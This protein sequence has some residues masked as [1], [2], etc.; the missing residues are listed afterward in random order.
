M[1]K[2]KQATNNTEATKVGV[3]RRDLFKGAGILGAGALLT[4]T[5]AKT[6][7]AATP[8]KSLDVSDRWYIKKVSKATT[9]YDLSKTQRFNEREGSVRGPGYQNYV[10]EEK[11][12]ERAEAA[13]EIR[14]RGLKENIPGWSL[15]DQALAHAAGYSSRFN[16]VMLQSSPISAR[17]PEEIGAPPYNET[18]EVAAKHLKRAA[19]ALGCAD[20]GITALRREWTYSVGGDGRKIEFADVDQVIEE[21]DR[22]IIPNKMNNIIVVLIPQPLDAI[23]CGQTLLGGGYTGNLAYRLG[24]WTEGAIAEFIRSLGYNAMPEQN[25]TFIT[26]PHAIEA[27]L[28][29]LGRH[30]R[31]IHPDYSM[32]NRLFP[33]L[34]DMP[35]AHDQPIDFGV[36]EFCKTCMKCAEECPAGCISFDRDPTWEIKGPWNNPGHKAWFE[37]AVKCRWNMSIE[38]CANCQS[39]CPYTKKNHTKI[40]AAVKATIAK[41]SAFNGM[42]ASMDD[43]FAYGIGKDP[44]NWWDLDLPRFGHY[45]L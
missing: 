9:E 44:K 34:T 40:H 23:H 43:M 33:I 19:I 36:Q 3:S 41:T 10:G 18:P 7:S 14:E 17:T 4:T 16:N 32:N 20:V 2:K 24:A 15:L 28:G 11:E 13:R 45:E 39:A 22:R 1:S 35:L 25:N 21:D 6:V 27:G 42:I 38:N 12:K 37:D 8:N 30:N 26:V 29:E 5:T 31:L